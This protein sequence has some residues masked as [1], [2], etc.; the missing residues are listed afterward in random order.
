MNTL[1]PIQV[2][3][4]I[5]GDSGRSSKM[6]T[7]DLRIVQW[8]KCKCWWRRQNPVHNAILS[9]VYRSHR[10]AV[11]IVAEARRREQSARAVVTVAGSWTVLCT[12]VSGTKARNTAKA[13]SRIQTDPSMTVRMRTPTVHVPIIIII[14]IIIIIIIII[15][16]FI[17]I[18]WSCFV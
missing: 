13:S 7:A 4:S 14:V 17:T 11:R 16:I 6:R 15:F 1:S 5:S 18:V 2:N 12:T 3:T 9:I 10:S 8:L